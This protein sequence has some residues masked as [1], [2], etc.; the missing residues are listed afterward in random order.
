MLNQF[1]V[2]IGDDF[3]YCFYGV[4]ANGNSQFVNSFSDAICINALSWTNLL[5]VNSDVYKL[6]MDFMC[7]HIFIDIL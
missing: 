3:W 1:S 2:L 6:F 5:G 4:D 7:C